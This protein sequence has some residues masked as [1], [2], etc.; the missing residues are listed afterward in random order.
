MRKL[1]LNLG[2]H[3][4]QIRRAAQA[5]FDGGQRYYLRKSLKA[6]LPVR[7]RK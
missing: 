2:T 7:V 3:A 6:W 4:A 1:P 5:A